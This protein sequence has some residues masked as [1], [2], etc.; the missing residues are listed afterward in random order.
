MGCMRQAINNVEQKFA[1]VNLG[2]FE[3]KNLE[4]EVSPLNIKAFCKII[5]AK[6]DSQAKLIEEPTGEITCDESE[7][8]EYNFL[9]KVLLYLRYVLVEM[10][11]TDEDQTVTKIKNFNDNAFDE[12]SVLFINL[13]E[14]SNIGV[15]GRHWVSARYIEGKWYYF[16]GKAKAPKIFDTKKTLVTYLKTSTDFTINHKPVNI[17]I[18]IKL[19]HF[20]PNNPAIITHQRLDFTG[21]SSYNYNKQLYKLLKNMI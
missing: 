11:C 13:G 18:Y 19:D 5:S 15:R 20:I 9:T 1:V 17:S 14:I 3:E 12:N 6:I 10:Y 16:D 7:N 2:S 8:Y 4:E 21:G